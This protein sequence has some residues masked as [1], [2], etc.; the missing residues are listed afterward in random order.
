MNEEMKRRG[1]DEREECGER[2]GGSS[3]QRERRGR[4]YIRIERE[5]EK[6]I[7]KMW[8]QEAVRKQ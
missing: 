4:R 7:E 8:E 1:S 5:R 2:E 3:G 6:I